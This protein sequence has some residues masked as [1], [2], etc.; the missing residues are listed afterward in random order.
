MSALGRQQSA[1]SGHST[2]VQLSGA[3]Q[4]SPGLALHQELQLFQEAGLSPLHA[5]QTVTING[6]RFLGQGERAAEAFD[7]ESSQVANPLCTVP[8]Q[9]RT[10]VHLWDWRFYAASASSKQLH[11]YY[12]LRQF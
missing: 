9:F 10:W 4:N 3:G 5:L 1:K 12:Q 11:C 2:V 8:Q 6:A 7:G